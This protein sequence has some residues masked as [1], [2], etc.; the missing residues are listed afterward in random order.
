MMTARHAAAS[1]AAAIFCTIF[2]ASPAV[3]LAPGAYG[4]SATVQSSTA[5]GGAVCPVAGTAVRGYLAYDSN[6]IPFIPPG[7]VLALTHRHRVQQ[8]IYVLGDAKY[9]TVADQKLHYIIANKLKERKGNYSLT[10]IN[11]S[12]F[13]LETK[14]GSLGKGHGTC[15]TTYG[16][17]LRSGVRVH[18]DRAM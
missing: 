4:I 17:S 16:I 15:D 2:A 18:L 7:L 5:T 9:A 1:G 12:S 10:V 14:T 8:V 11:N 3:S 13:K 6:D